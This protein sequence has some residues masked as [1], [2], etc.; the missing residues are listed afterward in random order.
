MPAHGGK[1]KSTST[2]GPSDEMMS[3]V[4][5]LEVTGFFVCLSSFFNR[6][7]NLTCGDGAAEF[8]VGFTLKRSDQGKHSTRA[9]VEEVGPHGSLHSY[10]KVL[11][12]PL[13]EVETC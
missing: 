11:F 1:K 10:L 9:S 4:L 7:E 12:R 8:G 5:C 3:E 6:E 13:F 2:S